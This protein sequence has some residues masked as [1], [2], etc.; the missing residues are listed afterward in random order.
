[1]T[2]GHRFHALD[3]GL[4][5]TPTRWWETHKNDMGD[6]EECVCMMRLWFECPVIKME[7]VYSR[8]EDPCRHLVRW[9]QVWGIEPRLEW[10]HIFIHMLRKVPTEWYLEIGRAHV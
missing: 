3:L 2:E 10:V 8:K 1:M 7:D 9:N 4:C 5:A 6:L